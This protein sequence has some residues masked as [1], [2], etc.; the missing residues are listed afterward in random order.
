MTE[1]KYDRSAVST[2][3]TRSCFVGESLQGHER[4]RL[5]GIQG[6]A[7]AGTHVLIDCDRLVLVIDIGTETP[8]VIHK[9]RVLE[10]DTGLCDKL[11]VVIGLLGTN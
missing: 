6:R 10:Q 3:E 5:I 4:I 7:V 9:L 1:L 11:A 8:R 2:S